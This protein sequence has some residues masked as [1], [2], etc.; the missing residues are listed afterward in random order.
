MKILEKLDGHHFPKLSPS[1]V[2]KKFTEKKILFGK[3][4]IFL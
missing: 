2:K 3:F 4:K 1:T